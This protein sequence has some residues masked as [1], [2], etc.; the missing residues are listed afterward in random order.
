MQNAMTLKAVMCLRAYKKLPG[1][2]DAVLRAATL[3][4]NDTGVQTTLVL[5]GVSYE[6]ATRFGRKYLES[7]SWTK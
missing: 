7:I 4:K 3:D 5:A 6:N 2:Y 1:L